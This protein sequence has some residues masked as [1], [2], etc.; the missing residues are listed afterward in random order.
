VNNVRRPDTEI[1]P[2][3]FEAQMQELKN[4]NISV[5][6]MQDF[7]AW[8]RGEKAI[9]PKS[10]IITF[11]D[12]WKSQYD[13]AWPIL[14]KF[15]YPVTLFIYT[16]GIRPGH[17]SGGESMG[18]EHL[19]EMRDAGVDIQGHSATHSDLRKPYDKVA[20]KKLSPEEYE[21]WLKKEL[22]DSKQMIEQKLG[23]KVNC[24]AVPY[25]FYNEHIRDVTIKAGYE[26]L[27]TVYGQ[28]IT[29]HTP[30]N[31]VGR[32]LME[33][34]KPKTFTDAVAAIATTAAGPAVSEVSSSNLQTQPA[35]GETVKNALPLIKANIA[36]LGTIDPGSVE[37]RVSG[38]GKVD[39]S[40]DPKSTTVAYQVT[41]RLRDK[42]C[43][44]I[45]SAKSGGKRVETHWTFNIDEAG[46]S[47]PPAASAAPSTSASPTPA[48][49]K[50]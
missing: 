6:P 24:L 9:P 15:N 50:K 47:A 48:P 4:K 43:T 36:S 20:K 16:E 11:D 1:T 40:F 33:A 30:L 22:V 17:F 8:R 12:G 29:M 21:A 5:I 13:V 32:Y 19:A 45:V 10:A 44:V 49:K 18:W 26:A 31:S 25:G 35:E 14:K 42:T 3:A 38:L 39:A 41:Q 28:P 34:N 2:A 7:L 27:F 46:G 37:M 23:V